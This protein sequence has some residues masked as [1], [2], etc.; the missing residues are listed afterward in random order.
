[1]LKY[2]LH[3]FILIWNYC[4]EYFNISTEFDIFYCSSCCLMMRQNFKIC[5]LYYLQVRF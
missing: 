5:Y 2:D 4:L 1:V 3:M